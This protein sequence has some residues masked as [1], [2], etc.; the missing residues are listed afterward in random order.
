MKINQ[1]LSF[2]TASLIALAGSLQAQVLV[3]LGSAADYVAL[4]KTAIT[5]TS[6]TAIVGDLGISPAALTDVAGFGQTLDGTGQFAISPMVTGKIFA[7]DMGGQTAVNLTTAISDMEA[8]FTDAAGRSNP[9]FTDLLSGAL[10]ATTPNLTPGLYKWASNVSVTDSITID[11]EG[12]SN[13]FWIFQ[14]DNR[15]SLNTG[16]QIFLSGNANPANIF[17]QTVEGATIGTN[18][19]FVGNILTQADI[20]LQTGASALGRLLAQTAVTF[21]SNEVTIVPESSSYAAL[22]GLGALSLVGI[23]RRVKQ[24]A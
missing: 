19:H 20:A 14:I 24:A 16:A 9:D 17:W 3:N 2:A 21:D 15:L 18:A 10:T 12:D 1:Y 13:A 6:G 4:G 8:A 5:T 23:R 22:L 7:A 11:G